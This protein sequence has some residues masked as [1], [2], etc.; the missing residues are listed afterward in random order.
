MHH[1]YTR[2][3]AVLTAVFLIPFLA[4]AQNQETYKVRIAPVARDVAMQK[5]VDGSG[6][7]MA[8]LSGNKLTITGTFEG[9]PSAATK[10]AIHRGLTTGVRGSPFLDLSVTKAPK[11]TISGSFDLT[12]EQVQYLKQGKLYIQIDSEKAPDGTLWGWLLK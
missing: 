3:T 4:G 8:T 5:S 11:G 12:S 7:A 9:M 6:S 2:C 1:L 10:A